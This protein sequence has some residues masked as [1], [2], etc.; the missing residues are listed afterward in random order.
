VPNLFEK[1][2]TASN[3]TFQSLSRL[4]NVSFLFTS[5]ICFSNTGAFN[6]KDR[7]IRHITTFTHFLKEEKK[8]NF[9]PNLLYIFLYKGIKS[10]S[11]ENILG[12]T[13]IK[14]SSQRSIQSPNKNKNC[15]FSD[16]YFYCIQ[17]FTF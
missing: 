15:C 2:R 9:Y 13:F 11:I 5:S 12:E 4:A 3:E 16:F 1:D 8:Y 10:I 7:E 17:K 6:K 14:L